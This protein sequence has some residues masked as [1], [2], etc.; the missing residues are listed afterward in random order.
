MNEFTVQHRGGTGIKCY[1]ISEKT[2]NVVGVKAV[3]DTRE[4]M[5]ITTEGVI[6]QIE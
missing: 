3:D 6:I 2:G 1:K 5:L 4:V